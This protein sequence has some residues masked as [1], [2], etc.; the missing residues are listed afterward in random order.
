MFQKLHGQGMAKKAKMYSTFIIA[1]L[2][3]E[4]FQKAKC[5]FLIYY[6]PLIY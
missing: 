6:M 4:K 3:S 2:K 1:V 5:G